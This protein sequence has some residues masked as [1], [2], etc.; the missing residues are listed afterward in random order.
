VSWIA[1]ALLGAV[2]VVGGVAIGLG[3]PLSETGRGASSPGAGWMFAAFGVYLLV[4]GF[5][6]SVDPPVDKKRRPRHAT[7][8]APD[9]L[10]AIGQPL[11]LAVSGLAGF[12]GIWWGI[13]GGNVTLVWFGVLMASFVVAGFPAFLDTLRE[14]PPRR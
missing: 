7:G 6:R 14:G 4:A 13:A 8:R 12:G 1:Q 2:W 10:T 9:R 3:P 5:R 11:A